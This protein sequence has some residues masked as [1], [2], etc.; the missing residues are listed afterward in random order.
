MQRNFFL[1]NV[2]LVFLLGAACPTVAW[3]Q[4]GKEK[5][6]LSKK[7]EE[8]RQ[9]R[10]NIKLFQKK[11]AESSQKESA[12]LAELDN[13]EKQNLQ[14][15][16]VIK[17]IS[18]EVALNA[19]NISNVEKQIS[20][21]SKRLSELSS[22][23]ANFV[24][25]F[26]EQ[27]RLHD[28]EL[29]LTSASVN[30]MLI[31][32]EY[33]K[34]FSER[35]KADMDSIVSDRKK[36]NM[37]REQLSNRL[38]QQ[39]SLLSQQRIE[40]AKLSKRIA[41]QK[42]M[43]SRLRHDKKVYEEQLKRSQNAA[44]ELEGLIRGLIAEEAA[45]KR[46]AEKALRSSS[47]GK[48]VGR[49]QGTVTKTSGPTPNAVEAALDLKGHLPWPVDGGKI[50]SKF[51]KQ[52]NP[53]LRTV[54]L[55]YGIDISVPENSQVKSVADGEV[56]RIFW[57]PSYGNLIIIN[58]YDGLR[59]VYSHLGDI[60]VKEGEKVKLGEPIGAVGESLAGSVLHF[61]VWLDRDKQDPEAW[62]SKK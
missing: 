39:Q 52:E 61:E 27:G 42:N 3:S 51:G 57:L 41:E 14:T 22:E 59:T 29:I 53:V 38:S 37:L 20:T 60:F 58:N 30:E 17:K 49:G 4:S 9:L 18:S 45:R 47:S 15:R 33:L 55:N 19:Q 62:L 13:F 28:L 11:I 40:E 46:E 35:T 6:K 24:R 36:L 25:S 48:A 8:L 43:I 12:S 5:P 34:R 1:T 10:G 7:K 44:I 31:R 16:Q 23:Y 21:A 26:Y 50:V 54:T 56:S 32:Y 2:I